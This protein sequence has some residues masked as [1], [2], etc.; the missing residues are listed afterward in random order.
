MVS[1]TSLIFMVFTAVVTTLGSIIAAIV[2][3]RKQ[4]YYIGSVFTGAAVFFLF[5]IVLRIPIL[6][7]VLPRMEW[8]RHMVENSLWGYALFLGFTAGLFEEVGRYLAFTTILKKR[9]DWKNAVAFG[10]GHGGIESILLVGF[11]YISN[12]MVS[13]MINSGMYDSMIA[14][15]PQQEDAL[16]QVKNTLVETPSYMYLLGGAER[17][18]AFLIHIGLSVLIMEGIR[19]K[20][21]L[22]YLGLAILLHM[23]IDS[24]VVILS[25]LG[26]DILFVEIL[27]LIFAI[28]AFL[29]VRGQR[30]KEN[31][32][33]ASVDD[34]DVSAL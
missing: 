29:Y 10:I 21:G 20:K 2:F 25:G 19:K 26:A 6:Q 16:M 32:E 5:Q 30:K 12:L 24:P 4:K 13:V 1:S 11:T 23:V 3:Y 8:Y 17:I 15:Y 27:V 7:L 28:I 22:L 34:T 18:F 14:Q 9:L 33:N 31:T